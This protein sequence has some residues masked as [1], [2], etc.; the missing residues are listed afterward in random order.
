M[1]TPPARDPAPLRAAAATPSGAVATA[2]D[3]VRRAPTM[4]RA[5]RLVD[6]L[7]EAAAQDLPGHSLPLLVE[8]ARAPRDDLTAIAAVHA[9]GALPGGLGQPI[10]LTLLGARAEEAAHL[11]EHAVWALRAGRPTHA[12]LAPLVASVGRGGFGGMLAQRTLEAWAPSV[13]DAVRAVLEAALT[14]AEDAGSRTRL[15]ETLGLVPGRPTVAL[16]LAR[17]VDDEEPL[18]SRAA[19]VAALGDDPRGAGPEVAHVL[20]TLAAGH[21]PLAQTAATAQYDLAAAAAPARPTAG[22]GR[23]P[24]A[25]LA[26]VQLFLHADVDAQLSHSGRGDNG[27]IATLLVQLGDAL[28]TGDGAVTRTV[29]V[30]RGRPADGT[31]GF[32]ALRDPGHHYASVPLLGAPVHAA[33][34]WPMRVVARRG[35]RRILRAAAPVDVVH[36][37]M[38]DVGS[39]AAAEAA[40]EL[41]VPVV[42][43]L[44]PDPHAQVDARDRAGTLTR[45]GFGATDHVEHLV[46]RDRLLR[47]LADRAAHLVLF[48]RPDL[49]Q[50]LCEL[51]GVDLTEPTV[52]ASVVAEGIDLAGISRAATVVAA[53]ENAGDPTPPA[54]LE[55]DTVLGSLPPHRRGLP[56]AL[57]VGRLHPVKGMATLVETWAAHPELT[58]RCNLLV[59][60]GD[61]ETPS[62]DEA[63]ELARIHAAVPPSDAAGRGLILAGHRPNPVVAVWMAATRLGRPGLAAPH[64]VY[65]SA[66]LKEE[67]GIAIVEATASGL[68]VVAPAGG[69]PATYVQEGLTGVLVDTTSPDALAEALA[70]ALTL[71]DDPR[72][73]ERADEARALVRDRFGIETMATAL[74]GVYRRVAAARMQASRHD[75]G[76]D[77][78]HQD[79]AS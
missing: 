15:V 16:L 27:G 44:A 71:A 48:P 10:L 38:A 18:A 13:P 79:V 49:H 52:R 67:F 63:R 21:G 29:T 57:T 2:L 35:I 4:V 34:A 56:I 55:L 31:T 59:V 68:F 25:D 66:S 70:R 41:G 50:D 64:G 53:T 74:D 62:D 20:R 39:M 17:A 19:A 14:T 72:G 65:V 7:V 60:G 46:F 24:R 37:R 77:L 30:S 40:A 3:A 51:L 23:V 28:M 26:V 47:G 58:A 69:G 76:L 54:L 6:D 33:D 36:L 9:L 1:A 32:D 5:L 61:L 42:L 22:D 12:A 75:P 43:T 78:V 8:A 45:A 11:R 73:T